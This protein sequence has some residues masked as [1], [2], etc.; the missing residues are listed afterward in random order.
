MA[1][2]APS[3]SSTA[4]DP[5]QVGDSMDYDL[6]TMEP[7][8]S[9]AS[10]QERDAQS[11]NTGDPFLSSNGHSTVSNLHKSQINSSGHLYSLWAWEI[12]SIL[13]SIIC[14]GAI[15]G[16][17]FTYHSKAVP[18]LPSGLTLNALISLL[19]T[20]SK[21]AML[22]SVTSCLS[23]L[24]WQWFR[25]PQKLVHFNTL[26]E[27]SRGP[28]GSFGLLLKIRR[29]S[30]VGL[31]ALVVI[32]AVGIDPFMQQVISYPTT[33][34]EASGSFVARAQAYDSGLSL[35][36]C[37]WPYYPYP[38]SRALTAFAP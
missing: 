35:R 9:E 38:A 6:S 27:A 11:T 37:K 10:Y 23:Q 5:W 19:A 12:I 7:T 13:F 33:S 17:L 24:K 15:V 25:H 18:T 28:W 34:I 14:M 21:A 30:L 26:D 31:G 32:L 2:M 16:V 4:H 20:I 29:P 22:V 1:S 3:S 8:Q 36:T